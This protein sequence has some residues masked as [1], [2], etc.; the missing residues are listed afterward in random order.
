MVVGCAPALQERGDLWATACE[1][2]VAK[3]LGGNAAAGGGAM[4]R[5]G[6]GPAAM[7]KLCCQ[8]RSEAS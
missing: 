8:Q 1:P 4:P 6:G 7:I 3:G 2:F 5:P